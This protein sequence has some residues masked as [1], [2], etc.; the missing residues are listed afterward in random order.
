[1]S[2]HTNYNAA[3]TFDAAAA[4]AEARASGVSEKQAM[5]KEDFLKLLVAQLSHQDPLNPLAGHEFAAQLAQFTSVEQLININESLGGQGEL[6]SILAQSINSGV[7]AGLIGK[8]IE[9]S[10]NT[11]RM[12]ETNMTMSGSVD[13]PNAASKV[14]VNIKNSKGDV[15][16]TIELGAQPAGSHDFEWDGKNDAGA[17]VPAGDYSFEVKASDSNGDAV[18]SSPVIRGIVERVT[19]SAEGIKLWVNGSPVAMGAVTSV[20]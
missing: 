3:G 9:A 17:T 18:A 11:F 6:N 13:L 15:V 8:N 16:K 7:A 5:G 2:V 4:A 14:T 1:M 10:A 19:F 20:E 12:D